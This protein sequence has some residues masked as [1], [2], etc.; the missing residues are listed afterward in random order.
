[1]G[2]SGVV[3]FLKILKILFLV[4]KSDFHKFWVLEVVF[5]YAE[6]NGAS[7]WALG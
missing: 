4:P 7:S 6:C 3:H 2:C 1:M 5:R